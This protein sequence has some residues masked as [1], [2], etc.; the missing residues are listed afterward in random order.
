MSEGFHEEEILGKAY[1]GRLM[2]RLLTYLR[3][4]WF[5]AL[6]AFIATLLYGLLQAVPP[7]LLKLQVDRYLDPSG[8][9]DLPRLLAHFLSADPRLGVIQ[10]AALL[11]LPASL[12][13]FLLEF[14]Q[15]YTMQLVGQKVMFD[16]RRQ[17]FGHLQRLQLD[18][19][20]RNPVGR[21]VTR[22]TSDV[23]VLNDLFA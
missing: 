6:L 15:S 17:I 16:L 5:I 10:I 21:M 8:R 23:D 3:P 13:S 20:D 9:K 2:R 14:S 1:D 4:Y 18:F 11:F 22:V 19:Y 12:L 7:Y